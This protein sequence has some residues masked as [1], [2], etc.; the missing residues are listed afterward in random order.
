[1]IRGIQW[2]IWLLISR[3]VMEVTQIAEISTPDSMSAIEFVKDQKTLERVMKVLA[4]IEHEF[5]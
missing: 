3:L 2:S 1:M 4:Q 5:S